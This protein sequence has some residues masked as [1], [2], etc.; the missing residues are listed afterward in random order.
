M[1]YDVTAGAIMQVTFEGRLYGQQVLTVMNYILRDP[2]TL[3]GPALLEEAIVWVN[4]AGAGLYDKY[5]ACLSEDV[6][7]IQQH[8]Q[9]IHPTRYAFVTHLPGT[10]NGAIVQSAKTGNI[11]QVVTR[12]TERAGRDQVSNLHLPGVPN[13]E[14]NAG[15][16]SDGHLEVLQAFGGRSTLPM[17]L[18]GFVTLY[19]C[20]FRRSAPSDGPTLTTSYP[21]AQARDMRRR[22]VG[23][24]A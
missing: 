6:Q 21:Q 23:W 10:N 24:G 9:W 16:I 12:R 4:V 19:P 1:S 2:A 11:S 8:Y 3:D 18:G 22:T 5:I 7:L 15:L 14:V 13:E 17:D 20:P